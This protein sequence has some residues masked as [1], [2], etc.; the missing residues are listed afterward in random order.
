MTTILPKH[1]TCIHHVYVHENACTPGDQFILELLL[2]SINFGR[3]DSGPN[4]LTQKIG[5]NDPPTKAET[6]HPQ[7]WPKRPRPKRLRPKRPRAET[8]RIRLRT[9][10][11]DRSKAS[12][13]ESEMAAEIEFLGEVEKG[14]NKGKILT[15]ND[16]VIK[17]KE[18]RESNGVEQS[19]ISKKQMKQILTENVDGIQ[20]SKPARLNESERVTLKKTSDK[21]IQALE[22]THTET[23]MQNI[24]T[25]AKTLRK[26][27]LNVEPWKF[28]GSVDNDEIGGEHLPNA[29]VIFFR[30]LI[31]GPSK[32]TKNVDT[33]DDQVHSRALTL[34]QHAMYACLTKKQFSSNK[35]TLTLQHPNEWP[36]QLSVGL[37]VHSTFRSKDNRDNSRIS[38]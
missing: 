23:D 6:T 36:L 1:L 37:T 24:F 34:A 26:Q 11:L 35:K 18:I 20:F 17:F 14:L 29:L 3:N 9:D 15:M 25:V 31:Q 7:N 27:M 38:I 10:T 12:S 19:E 32:L 8:T 22:E 4:R 30:W 5:R 33:V 28:S 2:I 16:L 13:I 21:A